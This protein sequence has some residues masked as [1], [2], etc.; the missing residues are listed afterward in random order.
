MTIFRSGGPIRGPQPNTVGAEEFVTED[1][2]S[3]RAE[4]QSA[5]EVMV[6]HKLLAAQ[7]MLRE[8]MRELSKQPPTG[9]RTAAYNTLLDAYNELGPS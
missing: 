1:P 7:H 3:F 8:H 9:T 6:R 4:V 5:V 2:L